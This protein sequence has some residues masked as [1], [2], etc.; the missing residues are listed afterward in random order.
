MIECSCPSNVVDDNDAND[1]TQSRQ[2]SQDASGKV[3]GSYTIVDANGAQRIVE[4]Y[5]D[6]TGFH[7]NIKSNEP[8]IEQGEGGAGATYEKL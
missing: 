8:G 7:A 3:T 6:D 2:E 1:G 4:Y 5:A